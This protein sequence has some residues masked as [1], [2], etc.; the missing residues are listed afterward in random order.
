MYPN[1]EAEMARVKMSKIQLAK[2]IHKSPSVLSQKMA[3]RVG[4][5]IGEAFEIKEAI[6]CQNVPLD[7]LFS[8]EV[9]R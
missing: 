4:I 1:L 8:K 5:D 6:G 7:V 2:K 9:V 3:G